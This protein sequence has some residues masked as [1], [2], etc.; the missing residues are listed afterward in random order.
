MRHLI[1]TLACTALVAACGSGGTTAQAGD[2]RTEAPADVAIEVGQ[3]L[4]ILKT[5]S[6]DADCAPFVCRP[7]S[8]GGNRYCLSTAT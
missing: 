2:P 8:D 7:L 1:L 6:T 5:C 3:D 4:C